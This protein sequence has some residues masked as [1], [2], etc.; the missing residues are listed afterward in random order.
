M[1]F[2]AERLPF[3]ILHGNEIQAITFANLIDMR[4]V[5]MIEG[6][7]RLRLLYKTTHAVLIDCKLGGQNLQSHFAVELS[8][9]RQVNL[10]HPAL[11][12]LR[13][14]FVAAQ[15]CSC[16]NRHRVST[17]VSYQ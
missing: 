4:H 12:Q 3:Y 13:A 6:C 14:D 5:W 7:S 9:V 15:S 2:F 11:A 16:G 1:N 8:V 10:A 17:V